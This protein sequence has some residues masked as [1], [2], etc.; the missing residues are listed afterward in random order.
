MKS[1]L[2]GSVIL[3]IAFMLGSCFEEGSVNPYQKLQ[4]D[5]VEID[6]YL[7]ANPPEDDDIIVRDASGLRMVITEMGTGLVPPTPE[8]IIQVS[9]VGRRLSNGKLTESFDEDTSF[10]LTLTTADVGPD[11]IAGWKIALRMMTKGTKARV[12]I[13]SVLGYGAS[14]SGSIPGNSILVFDM[15]LKVVHTANEQPRLSDDITIITRYIA[16]REIANAQVHPSGLRYVINN[17][18]TGATPGL[19][20]QV[21]IKYTGKLLAD[22]EEDEVVFTDNVQIGPSEAFSS[23]AVNYVHGLI[24]GLQLMSAGGKA[25]FY[26]PS[27][28]G[29]G[30]SVLNKI[31]ANSNLIYEVELLEVIPNQE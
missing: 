22:D 10:T 26:L 15:E 11:V 25:T 3:L 31:P 18:G 9:Y 16:E 2:I 19:Y 14:G 4:Q 5:I 6:K 13:P 29:Y 20:D 30:P 7:V 12:Y 28:L 21:V 23:R 17:A 1:K 24:H 8:N 27:A